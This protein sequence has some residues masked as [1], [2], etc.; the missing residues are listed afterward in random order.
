VGL[1]NINPNL[2]LIQKPLPDGGP[3]ISMVKSKPGVFY[4][5]KGELCTDEMA[6][7]AG[8]DVKALKLR[9]AKDEALVKAT[10]AIEER[11]KTELDDETAAIEEG[12]SPRTGIGIP[13]DLKGNEPED[14]APFVLTTAGDE[15]RVARP[16]RDGPVKKMDYIGKGTNRGWT[17]KDRDSGREI[18]AGLSKEDATDLL[19][20]EEVE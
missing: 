17:V 3:R 18:E 7:S 5:A 20:K 11:F 2:G 9:K 19:L 14:G 8:F 13:A 15:P 10:A 12:E 4:D 16:T 6:E 1:E